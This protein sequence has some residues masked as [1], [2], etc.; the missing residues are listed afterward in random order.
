[1]TRLSKFDPILFKSDSKEPLFST[2]LY[3]AE[4][5]RIFENEMKLERLRRVSELRKSCGV[6]S[7]MMTI[8][9]RVPR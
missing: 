3:A 7:P 4:V 5:G 2:S 9:V 6:A 8:K 1:M